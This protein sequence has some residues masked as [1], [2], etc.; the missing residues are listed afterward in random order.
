[1]S[2]PIASMLFG[3][4]GLDIA[5]IVIYFAIIIGIGVWASRRVESQEDYSNYP[6]IPKSRFESLPLYVL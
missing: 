2:I 6:T 5:V 3:L 1:M 4:S